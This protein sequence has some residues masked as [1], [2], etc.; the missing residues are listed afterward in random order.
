MAEGEEGLNTQAFV[1]A[2]SDIETLT[3][4]DLEVLTWPVVVC[5]VVLQAFR[6]GCLGLN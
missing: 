3:V 6:E 1:V 4:N 2:V 5:W